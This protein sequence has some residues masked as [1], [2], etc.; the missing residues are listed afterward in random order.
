MNENKELLMFSLGLMTVCWILIYVINRYNIFKNP[1]L[2]KK[3][4]KG[5]LMINATQTI[6]LFLLL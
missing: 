3:M 5:F 4:T 6:F 2:K 1:E